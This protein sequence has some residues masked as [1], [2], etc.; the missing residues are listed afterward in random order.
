MALA[1]CMGLALGTE[2]VL[3]THTLASV[4]RTLG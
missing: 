3:A 1:V 2:M 4:V